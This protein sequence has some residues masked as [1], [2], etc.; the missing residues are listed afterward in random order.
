MASA[1]AFQAGYAGSIPVSR[2]DAESNAGAYFFSRKNLWGGAGDR[3]RATASERV[4]DD[5]RLSLHP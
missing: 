2:S 3:E 4:A 1:P 5:S